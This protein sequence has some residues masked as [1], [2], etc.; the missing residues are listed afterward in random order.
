M[1]TL[2]LTNSKTK[3]VTTHTQQWV[4]GKQLITALKLNNAVYEDDERI[5]HGSCQFCCRFIWH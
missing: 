1:Y 4:S 5:Y 3:E 2:E